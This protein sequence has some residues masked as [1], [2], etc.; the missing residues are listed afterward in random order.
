MG[1]VPSRFR[2]DLPGNHEELTL[3]NRSRLYESVKSCHGKRSK[4]G[5]VEVTPSPKQNNAKATPTPVK[6]KG[7]ISNQLTK[8]TFLKRFDKH[9][10]GASHTWTVIRGIFESTALRSRGRSALV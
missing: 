6:E 7:H 3:Q 10:T 4:D 9:P 5:D 8:G 2:D 1:L